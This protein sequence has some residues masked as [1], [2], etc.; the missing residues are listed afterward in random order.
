MRLYRNLLSVLVIFCLSGPVGLALAQTQT[1]P[2]PKKNCGPDHAILYKRACALLDTAEK[3]LKGRYVAE[4]KAQLKEANS[5]FSILVKECGQDQRQRLLTDKEV[6]QEAVNKKLAADALAQ[7]ERLMQSAA[8]K[9]KKSQEA[10]NQ[11]KKEES[12]S[13][14]RQAKGEYELAH[15]QSIKAGIYSLRNQQLIFRFLVR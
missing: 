5:L 11:G 14:Q 6:Q 3:K 12:V 9:E 7:S 1:P 13:L 15:T 10:E 8:A 4:A 2:P